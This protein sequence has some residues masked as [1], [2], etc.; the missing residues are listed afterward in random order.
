MIWY[1]EKINALAFAR[2]SLGYVWRKFITTRNPAMKETDFNKNKEKNRVP[3]ASK[4]EK[5]I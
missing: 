1:K 4:R 5:E 3:N 2:A